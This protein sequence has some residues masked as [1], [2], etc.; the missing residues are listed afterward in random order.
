MRAADV[1]EETGLYILCAKR[2]PLGEH[3][4]AAIHLTTPML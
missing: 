1:F 4:A 2:R 3:G